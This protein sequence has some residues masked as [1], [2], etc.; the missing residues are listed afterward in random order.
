M[1][2]ETEPNPPAASF[3]NRPALRAWLRRGGWKSLAFGAVGAVAG[4]IYA[5]LIGCRTGGCAILSNVGTATVAGGLIGLVFG[6]PT[7]AKKT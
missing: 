3:P 5:Q 4:G 1:P 7:P 6:W 2:L